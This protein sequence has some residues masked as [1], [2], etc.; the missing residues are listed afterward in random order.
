MISKKETKKLLCYY[1][2]YKYIDINTLIYC[3][4]LSMATY[5][6][7]ILQIDIFHFSFSFLHRQLVIFYFCFFFVSFLFSSNF[8]SSLSLILHPL[9]AYNLQF[10]E[11]SCLTLKDNLVFWKLIVEGPE[12]RLR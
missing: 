12:A 2:R 7:L 1:S 9:P 11:S 8:S 3:C 6:D 10:K 5:K 4:L